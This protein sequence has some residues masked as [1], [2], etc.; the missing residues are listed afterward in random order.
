MKQ[1]IKIFTLTAMVLSFV[2]LAD[3]DSVTMAGDPCK[4]DIQRLCSDVKPGG[5]RILQCLKVHEGQVSQECKVFVHKQ[6]EK[7]QKKFTTWKD[8]C[9]KDVN[10]LCPDVPIGEGRIINCLKAHKAQVS[11]ACRGQLNK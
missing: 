8:A 9:E 6:A 10:R 4:A 2:M 7:M 1:M 11:P 5:G 3:C